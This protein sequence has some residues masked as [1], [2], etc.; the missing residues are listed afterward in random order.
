[1]DVLFEVTHTFK[2]L[3]PPLAIEKAETDSN[4]GATASPSTPDLSATT[5]TDVSATADGTPPLEVTNLAVAIFEGWLHKGP[6]R[7]LQ[8]KLALIREAFEFPLATPV[9]R[10]S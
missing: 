10:Q 6:T 2:A 5:D 3:P 7:R 8:W 1:M 9:M 4:T